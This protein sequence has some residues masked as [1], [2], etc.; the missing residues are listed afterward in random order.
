MAFTPIERLRCRYDCAQQPPAPLPGRSRRSLVDRLRVQLGA[1]VQIALPTYTPDQAIPTPPP[2]D[3]PLK[4]REFLASWLY[5]LAY[6]KEAWNKQAK[7]AYIGILNLKIQ[8]YGP[9][10]FDDQPGWKDLG[11]R[12][13]IVLKENGVDPDVTKAFIIYVDQWI[14]EWQKQFDDASYGDRV[15][16]GERWQAQYTSQ[17]IQEYKE[18]AEEFIDEHGV[19]IG[20][21]VVVGGAALVAVGLALAFPDEARKLGQEGYKRAKRLVKK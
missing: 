5:T 14:A 19:G 4:I 20:A 16:I 15:T 8:Y 10:G 11:Q 3:Q 6:H 1:T 12:A 17:S 18:A 2:V 7:S 13:A 9:Q 21:G